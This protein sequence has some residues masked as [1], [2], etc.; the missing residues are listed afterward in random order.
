MSTAVESYRF[1]VLFLEHLED[2]AKNLHNSNSYL[3]N[4]IFIYRRHGKFL[5]DI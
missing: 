2:T 3:K 4:T 1:S 5:Q